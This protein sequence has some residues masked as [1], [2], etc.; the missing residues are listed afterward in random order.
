MIRALDLYAGAGGATRGLQL[1]GFHVTAVDNVDQPHNP[2][3]RFIRAD[4][5][6]LPIEYLRRFNLIWASPP[7]QHYTSLRHAP[8]KH[9]DADLIAATRELLIAAGRPYVLENVEGARPWLRSPTL[10]CGSMFGLETHPYPEGWRLERHRLFE[11]S[12]PL[13]AS[14]CQHDDRPVCGVYGAHFRDR[15]RAQ[16]TNHKSGSNIPRELG[17]KAMGI[18]LGTMTTSEISD[19][20][21]PAFARFI[22]KAGF[23]IR[24]RYPVAD[25]G[26]AR[27][28]ARG[29][30]THE[31]GASDE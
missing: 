22:A 17:F 21:P 14:A 10:L 30:S 24:D 29:F 5:L 27:Q 3:D 12:F 7:C 23:E 31:A 25:V 11:T 19:A 16:G 28:S 18:P 9:R 20:V 26:P 4:A 15:R 8:G 1:A 13:L 2:A 6:D